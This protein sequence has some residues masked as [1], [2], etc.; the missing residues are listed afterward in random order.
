MAGKRDPAETPLRVQAG[1]THQGVQALVRATAP[2]TL[3]PPGSG[4]QS[5]GLLSVHSY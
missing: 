3:L 5:V 2:A 1:L 4:L